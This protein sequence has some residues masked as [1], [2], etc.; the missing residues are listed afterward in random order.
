MKL[1]HEDASVRL[2]HGDAIDTPAEIQAD[3]FLIDPP[4]ARAGG[5]HT[6]RTKQS[7]KLED[8][9][10]ADQFWLYWFGDIAARMTWAMK[11]T[12]HGF[13]FCNEDVYPLVRRAFLAKT[14]WTVTQAL[15]WDR[16]ATG[17]GSPYRASFE[18]IAFA[19]GPQF[20]WQGRRDLRNVIRCRWPYGEHP[21]HEAEKPV[22]LLVRLMTEYSDAPPGSLWLDSFM[23]SATSA[24]AAAK[25]GRRM[26]ACEKGEGRALS[27]VERYRR[28]TAQSGLFADARA[29]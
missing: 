28:D 2:H 8:E 3:A 19:R 16:E 27:A 10:G 6:G 15:I 20:K 7:G 23:G 12:G 17:M 24:V 4:W 25:C 9:E 29:V 21:N 13:V 5:L 1:L 14:D 26:W 18:V 11:P 22:D